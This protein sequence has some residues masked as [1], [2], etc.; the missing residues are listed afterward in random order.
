MKFIHILGAVIFVGNIIVTALWKFQADRTKNSQIIAHAQ[1]LV[2][3]TDWVFTLGG[4]VLVLIGGY[5]MA[6]ISGIGLSGE[7]WLV[8]GQALFVVS[9]I[10]WIALLIPLQIAQ[11]KAAQ[12]F[13]DDLNI[14][15]IYWKRNRLW[16][17][18]GILAT[19]LPLVTLFFM[20][21]RP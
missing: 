17:I 9:A 1:G 6:G 3:L 11:H 4:V 2:T 21:V 8:W 14:P 16:Y 7:G 20:V 5:G 15:D 18:F 19:I 10:I 13:M 12:K